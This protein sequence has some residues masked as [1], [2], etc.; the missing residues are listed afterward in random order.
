MLLIYS[1][2]AA[3]ASSAL[4]SPHETSGSPLLP[5][6]IPVR[7]RLFDCFFSL[8]VVG[9]VLSWFI[10]LV[11]LLIK[12]ESR[13]PVF[14][15]QLRT[16]KQGTSFYCLKFRSMMLND[17]ADSIQA[18]RVDSRITKVG[19]FLRRT[20]LD[21][22]PQFINV[23]RGEMSIVGPRPHMLHHTKEYS[24][25]V[26]NFMDRHLVLPGITG[27]AQ[28]TGCRGE[29]SDPEAIAKRVSTDIHYIQTM[30]GLLDLKIIWLTVRLV[31]RPGNDTF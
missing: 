2:T 7:K 21:E 13:G 24:K 29:I 27:L 30:S 14:F 10:P 15:K 11:A 1:S 20:S 16:G 22:L 12:L 5:V 25:A 17:E 19:A 31:L 18:S 26:H 6:T 3:C 4:L 23:L 8:L 9:L 28:V